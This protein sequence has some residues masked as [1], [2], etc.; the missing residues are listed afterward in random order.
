MGFPLQPWDTHYQCNFSE[1]LAKL[2]EPQIIR[3]AGNGYHLHENFAFL[4]FILSNIVR[5]PQD[6]VPSPLVL[7]PDGDDDDIS[8]TE[9]TA[10]ESASCVVAVAAVAAPTL[11]APAPAPALVLEPDHGGWQ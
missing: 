7:M 11:S 4:V 5:R 2:T 1:A 10:S 3:M 8:S 6:S 9:R